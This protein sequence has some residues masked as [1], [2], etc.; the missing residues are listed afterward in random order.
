MEDQKKILENIKIYKIKE[1]LIKVFTSNYAVRLEWDMWNNALIKDFG[2]G[3]DCP[4]DGCDVMIEFMDNTSRIVHTKRS[5]VDQINN[6]QIYN[7]C[8]ELFKLLKVLKE[9]EDPDYC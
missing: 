6:L 3:I 5:I 2:K 7:N 8:R 1:K 9:Y 4:L